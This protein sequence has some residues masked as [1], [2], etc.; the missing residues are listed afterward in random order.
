[1]DHFRRIGAEN[2]GNGGAIFRG[3]II[4]GGRYRGYRVQIIGAHAAGEAEH[5]QKTWVSIVAREVSTDMTQHDPTIAEGP[6]QI[7]PNDDICA[8]EEIIDPPNKSTFRNPS[9]L[10]RDLP[11]IFKTHL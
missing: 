8:L 4:S 9:R 6:V 10:G 5:P 3:I 2:L 1:M 7:E 11:Y